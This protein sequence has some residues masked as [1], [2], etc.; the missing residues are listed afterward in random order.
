MECTKTALTKHLLYRMQQRQISPSAIFDVVRDGEII[1]ES[2]DSG[3]MVYLVLG[4][5]DG[6]AM[7][8]SVIQEPDTG[9]CKVKTA[10]EPEPSEWTAD[11]RRRR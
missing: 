2:E 6:R 10:Y 5:P 4:Y 1:E 9:I 8:V 3:E 7:H 11:F